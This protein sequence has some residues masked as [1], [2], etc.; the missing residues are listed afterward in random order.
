M[1]LTLRSFARSEVGLSREG[2]EDSGYAGPSCCRRRRH[3]WPRCRRGRAR[4]PSTRWPTSTRIPPAASL[5]D[6]RRCCR[7]GAAGQPPP[8]RCRRRASPA[9]KAWARRP[10][11]QFGP[12]RCSSSRTSVTPGATCCTTASWSRSPTTTPTFRRSSTKVASRPTRSPPSAR[13][14]ILRAL[15]GGQRRRG[16][17]VHH[18][19]RG[20][21]PLL[22]CSDGLSGL[23]SDATLPRCCS[24]CLTVRP[25]SHASSSS[26]MPPG[27]R[28]TSPAY[29]PMSPKRPPSHAST[30]PPRPHRRCGGR[31]A[32]RRRDPRLPV[33][34]SRV[35]GSEPREDDERQVDLEALRY[36]PQ[37][38]SGMRWVWRG[39]Q[40]SSVRQ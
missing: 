33:G 4:S 25:Q 18:P 34:G 10:P 6:A 19:G 29:S 23:V 27:H 36:A 31:R 1:A 22:L 7:G 11:R 12:G 21:R 39:L 37:E 2:N 40:S 3:G 32:R 35:R 17:P 13:S 28:T 38:P 20:W 24:A 14:Y 9:S 15:G 8:A 16:R 5:D 26:P 30:T